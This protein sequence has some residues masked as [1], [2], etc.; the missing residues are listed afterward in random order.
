MYNLIGQAIAIILG[1]VE[2]GVILGLVR[3]YRFLA[4]V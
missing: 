2:A 3:R 1:L 4:A